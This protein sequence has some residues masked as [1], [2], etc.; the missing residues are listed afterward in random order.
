MG[1]D[2]EGLQH[3]RFARF[4]IAVSAKAAQRGTAGHRRRL[5]AG[6]AGRVVEVGAGNG[7]N[8][9]HYP[10]GVD[11]V[12]A[13]EPESVLRAVAE[14]AAA[15]APVPVTVVAGQADD[16]PVGDG[17]ADAVVLSLVLCSV[18]DQARALAEVWRV[19]RPGGQVRFYEH[20]RS[21]SKIVGLM[22]DAITP[23]W[24]R[25]AG[26]CRPNRDT[27]PAI[28]DGGFAVA[29]VE[30]FG[31]APVAWSPPLRHTLGTA[32]KP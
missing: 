24:R 3:P 16:L 30:D 9:T 10:P 20:V 26:G 13:V 32:T 21:A 22:Q 14:A 29:A 23:V 19:L 18:P 12:V 4:Y 28:A 5:L 27:L 6:L 25:A 31:F 2:L 1:E 17:T 8:F 11:E 7:L 15:V